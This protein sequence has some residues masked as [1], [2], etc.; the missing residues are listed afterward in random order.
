MGFQPVTVTDNTYMMWQT[1]VAVMTVISIGVGWFAFFSKRLKEAAE[2]RKAANSA[3]NK[4]ILDAITAQTAALQNLS[5]RV[6]KLEP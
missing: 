4:A 6:D 1:I 3:E 2:Q 5:H